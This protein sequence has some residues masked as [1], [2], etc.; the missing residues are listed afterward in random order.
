MRVGVNL[1]GTD[2]E[3]PNWRLRFAGAGRNFRWAG[4]AAQGMLDEMR[5]AARGRSARRRRWRRPGEPL[6]GPAPGSQLELLKT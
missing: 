2:K 1:P 6:T 4:E 5:A 3:R